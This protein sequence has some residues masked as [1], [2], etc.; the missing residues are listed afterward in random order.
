MTTAL[1]GNISFLPKIH[2]LVL[3]HS[4]TS[5]DGEGIAV[6]ESHHDR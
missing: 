3:H 6:G 2:S 5:P 1:T 4:L